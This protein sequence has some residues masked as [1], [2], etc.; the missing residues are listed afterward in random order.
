MYVLMP[1][2]VSHALAAMETSLL[3]RTM[4]RSVPAHTA[5][6]RLLGLAIDRYVCGN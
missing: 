4:H 3:A 5:T 6:A 1:L 2:S